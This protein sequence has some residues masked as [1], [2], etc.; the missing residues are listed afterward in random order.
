MPVLFTNNAS[1]TLASS[2]TNVATVV[3]LTTGQ[4][5]LFP[6]LSGAN[7]FYATLT[8]SSNNIEV[9]KV[10]AR[11]SDALTV[12]RGQEGT[13]ARAYNAADKLE[14]RVTAAGL[15]NM[16]Q[17]D[18]A[19]T[20]T[21]VNTFS[22]TITSSGGTFSGTWAGTP[23]FSGA[24]SFGST[25]SFT[26]TA[27]GTAFA[28]TSGSAPGQYTAVMG[29]A[30]TWYGAFMRNDGTSVYLLSSAV[31]TT[32]AAAIT[33][34]FNSYRP[35]AWSL[36][37]GAVSIASS[38]EATSVGGSLTAAGNIT[39]YSDRSLKTELTQITDALAKVKALT[40]YTYTRIDSGE[41]QT[42]LIAQDVQKV[43]PEAVTDGEHLS[44]AYGNLMGLIC[45]AVKELDAKVSRLVEA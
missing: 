25:T 23:T 32:Q 6:A 18:A 20:F 8:D 43:L 29:S 3:N 35:F 37:T 17:L 24:V 22:G 33:A 41:R 39:A 16:A 26:G 9:V 21:G 15:G 38:G 34:T 13:T 30:S 31:Q 36:S 44:L 4:G 42:G 1:A 7:Y 14:I 5:A 10:T 11:T 28:A 19:Q 12:V 40:G 45:E 27:T 2:I